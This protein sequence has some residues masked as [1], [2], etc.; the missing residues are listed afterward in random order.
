MVAKEQKKQ[1]GADKADG[2]GKPQAA[3]ARGAM[4]VSLEDC[5][6]SPNAVLARER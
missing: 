6:S 2:R 3:M 5:F 4:A 1:R